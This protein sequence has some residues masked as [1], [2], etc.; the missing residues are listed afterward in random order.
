MASTQRH[1]RCCQC[2][3]VFSVVWYLRGLYFPRA[4][5][6]GVVFTH[7]VWNRM[8]ACCVCFWQRQTDRDRELEL[9]LGEK[10]TNGQTETR[11]TATE[12][13][14]SSNSERKRQTDGQTDRDKRDSDRELENT[15]GE[16]QT[17]RRDRQTDR[18]KRETA[19]KRDYLTTFS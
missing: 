14:A 18:D 11:E 16:K 1:A 13:S 4:G 19:T 2:C 8:S 7:N 12:N 9:K 10:Q 6:S 17:D 5:E 3:V 15:L